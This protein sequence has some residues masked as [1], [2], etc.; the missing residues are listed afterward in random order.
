M[1]KYLDAAI[2]AAHYIN[3]YQ[4]QSENGIYWD[5]SV[6]F[7]GKW[8]YYDNISMY[9]G[10]AGIIKFFLALYQRTQNETY[11]ETAKRAGDYLVYRWR[12]DRPMQKAFSPFAFTTGY[13]GVGFILDELNQVSAKQEYAETVADIANEII[14]ES[15]DKGYWSG[16]TGIVAD[17]GTVLF[18]LSLDGRYDIDDLE[19]TIVHFG[20]YLISTQQSDEYGKYYIGLDLKYVGGPIGKFN[21]GFPLGPAGG[22]FTLLKLYEHTGDQRFLDATQGVKEFY[23]NASLQNDA[24]LLPHYLPDE[25]HMCYAGY[26]GGPVGVSRYFYE[27]YK[28]FNDVRYLD[29]F[30]AA[31]RGLD[32]LGAPEERSAGYW[33]TEN[34]CCGTA[35]ILQLYVGAYLAFGDQSYFDLAK[36]TADELLKRATIDDTN[37]K[38]IQAFERKEP[39]NLTAALGYYDGAAGIATSLLQFD[40]L[41]DGEFLYHRV[42]D[43]PYPATKQLEVH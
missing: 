3:Q 25:T 12:E 17:G 9:A 22:A 19:R 26:C 1:T 23:E 11:L 2:K 40:Q 13:S 34:Y 29:D 16:Q 31:L 33:A 4:V 7:E 36:R 32:V 35:G 18:L 30:K 6:S 42:V 27:Y 28:Q 43:D 8:R 37:A 10:S 38:W 15:N 39:E 5:I 41:L 24:I 14:K 20:D 21:T